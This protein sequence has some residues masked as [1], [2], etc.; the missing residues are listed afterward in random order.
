MNRNGTGWQEPIDRGRPSVARIKDC[1]LG[2]NRNYPAD[3]RAV[4]ELL[5]TA[6][7]ARELARAGHDFLIR[8][9]RHLAE[10]HDIRQYLDHGSGLPLP[11][12]NLHEVVGAV[13]RDARVVYTDTDP[14][15]LAYGRAV[16]DESPNA[17]ILDADLTDTARITAGLDGRI[18][19]RRPVGVLLASAF[20]RIPGRDGDDPKAAVGEL[21]GL[22]APGSFVALCQLV[23]DDD[24]ARAA[25]T[26][27][28]RRQTGEEWGRART[29]ADVRSYFDLDRL[30]LEGPGLG[31]VT[32]WHPDAPPR[33]SES[34]PAATWTAFGGLARVV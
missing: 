24:D 29:E 31:D 11:A 12:L 33:G 6:P 19:L 5:E 13:H 26:G 8:T 14:M 23:S 22:L 10:K 27:L 20:H 32:A 17:V 25:L 9:A 21:I 18:D 4:A 15:V 30:A 2:G 1:L 16:L 3:Q 7:N 28:M 34:R